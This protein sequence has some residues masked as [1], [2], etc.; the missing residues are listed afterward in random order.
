M[1]QKIRLNEFTEH[2]YKSQISAIGI[3]QFD[4]SRSL[5]VHQ[6]A[7]SK[8]LNGIDPMPSNVENEIQAILEGLQPKPEKKKRKH[9]K[10]TKP[11]KAN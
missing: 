3:Q 4:L 1:I 6:S 8:Q 11:T 10:I 5:G 7:L 9:Q 2:P